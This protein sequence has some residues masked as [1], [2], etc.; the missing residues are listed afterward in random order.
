MEGL[1]S[2]GL[3][4]NVTGFR[5]GDLVNVRVRVRVAVLVGDGRVLVA[6][7]V[8]VRVGV[9][10]RVGVGVREGEGVLERVGEAERDWVRVGVLLGV[11]GRREGER[12][13]VGVGL[14]CWLSSSI[15]FALTITTE[16]TIRQIMHRTRDI[17][18]KVN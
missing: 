17:L 8:F 9:L 18:T 12:L 2:V 6:V 1:R 5:D 11:G 16:R 15:A 4:V 7:G 14:R 3:F 10:V 13:L